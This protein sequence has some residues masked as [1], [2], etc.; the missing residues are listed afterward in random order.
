MADVSL[1]RDLIAYVHRGVRGVVLSPSW[2]VAQ[3]ITFMEMMALGPL[4]VANPAQFFERI[5]ESTSFPDPAAR[6]DPRVLWASP[7]TG[8]R[9][10]L[11]EWASQ[12]VDA[13][14]PTVMSRLAP[15]TPDL[16]AYVGGAWIREIQ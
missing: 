3:K 15:E 2:T 16:T 9:V 1:G 6:T 11:A 4:D 13:G 5:E 8:L 7:D 10:N 14:S 12:A